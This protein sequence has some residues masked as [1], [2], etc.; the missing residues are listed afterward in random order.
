M[1]TV[2]KL[3]S[4]LVA[5]ISQQ[6]QQQ[7]FLVQE[8]R[9]K[10]PVIAND[11]KCIDHEIQRLDGLGTR[12]GACRMG[13]VDRLACLTIAIRRRTDIRKIVN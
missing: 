9:S 10:L 6:W 13:A 3:K 5:G 12:L 7:S 1:H 4:A 2:R 11:R 8:H